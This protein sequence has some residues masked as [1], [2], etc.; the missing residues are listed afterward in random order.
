MKELTA[1]EKDTISE[2]SNISLGASATALSVILN[3]N[4]DITTPRLNVV[5]AVLVKQ[6][7]PIP[8]LLVEVGYTSG[9]KGNNV[10]IIKEED[11]LVIAA[12][13][14]G[15]ALDNLQGPLKDIELSALQEAMTQMMGSMAT[16]MSELFQRP[17]DISPPAIRL[18]DLAEESSTLDGLEDEDLVV[19]VEFSIVV[20]DVLDSIMIQVIP[21]DF[22]K[23]MANYLLTGESETTP[24]PDI[25][26]YSEPEVVS[27]AVTD[28]DQEQLEEEAVEYREQTVEDNESALSSTAVD[29]NDLELDT[30]A[31]VGNISLGASATT[32]AT[33][34]EKSVEI[35]TPRLSIIQA[36][37]IASKHPVP[38]LMVEV[39]YTAGLEGS[40][41]LLI[42][43]PDAIA[44]ASV[45]IGDSNE[46]KTFPLNDIELSAVQEAMNQMMGSMATSMSELFQ[47]TIEISP[48]NMQLINLSDGPP[49]INGLE[50]HQEVVYIEFNIAVENVLDSVMIQV[51]PIQF[52]KTMTGFLLKT[53]H[54]E[55]PEAETVRDQAESCVTLDKTSDRLT[56]AIIGD[57]SQSVPESDKAGQT[58][59]GFSPASDQKQPVAVDWQK[60]DMVRD[61]PM[62]IVV[63]LG[64]TKMPLGKLF[65]LDRGS[66]VDLDRITG[67]PV[68]ILT[69]NR[70]LAKG[71][72]VMVNDQLGVR[73]TEIQI[74]ELIGSSL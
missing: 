35:T 65:S 21:I 61:I 67:E 39:K 7:Y 59:S 56:A 50:A 4:V 51:I 18:I 73:I 15:E 28:Q 45:M 58:S 30:L 49:V 72:I 74:E 17:I 14:S 34:L 8:C 5:K 44:I 37:E 36:G 69:N 63:V 41:V 11:A 22:A 12:L 13:M 1:L 53:E 64:A 27:E 31:E 6:K 26:D 9:L 48:T 52:A 29:L 38:C 57:K 43:E 70:L 3:R 2:V 16:S 68:E 25:A 33:I 47:R 23:E 46:E 42:K 19:H 10:L 24:A 54:Q 66:M 60:L 32:L 20:E 62:D 71:E 55:V 40:N